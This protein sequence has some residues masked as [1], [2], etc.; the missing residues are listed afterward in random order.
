MGRLER[1]GRRAKSRQGSWGS[2]PA[3]RGP[4][5][6]RITARDHATSL[7]HTHTRIRDHLGMDSW[8]CLIYSG[9]RALLKT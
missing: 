1:G 6:P 5:A 7:Q 3:S 9:V 4:L 2:P 8:Q